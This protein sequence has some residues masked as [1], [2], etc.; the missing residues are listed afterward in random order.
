M[1]WHPYVMSWPPPFVVLVM[2]KGD[3]HDDASRERAS[4]YGLQDKGFEPGDGFEEFVAES[5]AALQRMRIINSEPDFAVGVLPGEGLKRK[6]D[7]REWRGEHD[8]RAALWVAED[9]ELRGRHDKADFG[10]LA[11]VVDA[12]EYLHVFCAEDGFEAV[13]GFG[14]GVGARVG[15]EAVGCGH[16]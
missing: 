5:V 1:A 8:G 16:L 10:S 9:E 7:C 4:D 12:G 6:I 11:A 13:E 2:G 3:G 15:D 14:G